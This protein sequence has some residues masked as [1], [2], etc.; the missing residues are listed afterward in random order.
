MVDNTAQ[1]PPGFTEI[2]IDRGPGK[3]PLRFLGRICAEA[4]RPMST[5]VQLRYVLYE[6]S[7]GQFV[8]NGSRVR[9]CGNQEFPAFNMPQTFD[10]LERACEWFGDKELKAELLRQLDERKSKLGE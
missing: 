5:D 3:E 7:D 6:T 1:V 10:T 4:R 8:S 2:V 9:Y